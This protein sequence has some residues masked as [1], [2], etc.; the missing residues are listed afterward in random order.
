MTH[1]CVILA[2]DPGKHAGWCIRFGG[3]P[4]TWG[5]C[6]PGEELGICRAAQ[7]FASE[8]SLPLVVVAEK[9]TAG[10]PY[11]GPR[12]MAGLGAAWGRWDGALRSLQH[13]ARRVVRVYPQTWRA[14]VLSPRWGATSEQLKHLSATVASF[15]TG[16]I[17]LDHNAADAIGMSRWAERAP[18]VAAKIPKRRRRAA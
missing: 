8:E 3:K 13:P 18:E 4:V 11:S 15:D 10:G 5:S 14:A 6:A 1:P 12:T 16:E 7:V 17:I 9:W 2:I